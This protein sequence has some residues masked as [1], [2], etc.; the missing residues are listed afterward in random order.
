MN[1][2]VVIHFPRYVQILNQILYLN[3]LDG[4][5]YLTSVPWHFN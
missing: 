4:I 1:G 2:Y 3:V 5:D